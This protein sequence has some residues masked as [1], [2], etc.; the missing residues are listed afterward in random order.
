MMGDGDTQIYTTQTYNRQ[1]YINF[2]FCDCIFNPLVAIT[3]IFALTY[4]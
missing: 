3:R 4:S 1:L 2:V